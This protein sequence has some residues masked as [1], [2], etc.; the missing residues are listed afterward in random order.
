MTIDECVAMYPGCVV[1][2][3]YITFPPGVY[4]KY[5]DEYR[6]RFHVW[7]LNTTCPIVRVTDEEWVREWVRRT[8]GAEVTSDSLGVAVYLPGGYFPNVVS[9][10]GWSKV[11]EALGGVTLTLPYKPMEG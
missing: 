5:G 3:D 2:G 11:R 1:E 10:G 8:P 7:A 6:T 4:M 9:C